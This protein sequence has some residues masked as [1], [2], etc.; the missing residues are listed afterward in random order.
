MDWGRLLAGVAVSLSEGDGKFDSPGVDQGES[1]SIESTLSTV[2]PCARVN[3]TGRVSACGL[4]GWGTGDMTIRFD[5][6]SMAPVRTDIAMQLGAIGARD[7]LL[8][9]DEA[10]GGGSRSR[11]PRRSGPR[12]SWRCSAT[13]SP[14]RRT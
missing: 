1:G 11:R 2:I 13:A 6:G 7:A 9:Q 5:D 8:E 14:G 10:G 12:W 3:L 4:A